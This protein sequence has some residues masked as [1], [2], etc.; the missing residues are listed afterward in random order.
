[1]KK[2]LFVLLIC[3]A[4][5]CTKDNYKTLISKKWV[6]ESVTVTPAMKMGGKTSDNYIEL[7]GPQSCVANL[8]LSFAENG[9]YVAGANG[10]LC[11]MMTDASIKTWKR[12][13]DKIILSGSPAA[14]L[15]FDGKKLTQTATTEQDGRTYTFVYIYKS[16]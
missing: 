16:K 8:S 6:I 7:S 13:G 14:P 2:L 4:I 12:D 3:T 5:A 9:T 11:D 10:A 1:M 15:S